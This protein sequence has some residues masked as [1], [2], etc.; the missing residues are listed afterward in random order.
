MHPIAKPLEQL[1]GYL[2]I[3]LHTE[4]SKRKHALAG[5]REIKYFKYDNQV[6]SVLIF[7]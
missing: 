6:Y 5:F 1:S 7:I 3:L 2:R 4:L